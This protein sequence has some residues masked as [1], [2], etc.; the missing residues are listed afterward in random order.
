MV[1]TTG[2]LAS[3][4]AWIQHALPTSRP[5][6]APER[7]DEPWAG[8]IANISNARLTQTSYFS[9]APVREAQRPSCGTPLVPAFLPTAYGKLH[10]A[11]GQGR[12]ATALDSQA[13]RK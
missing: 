2:N 1:G 3:A 7:F 6:W 13:P 5:I 11:H 4:A 12:A 8:A 10:I 9:V